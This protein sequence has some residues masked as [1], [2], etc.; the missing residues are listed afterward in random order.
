MTMTSERWQGA[1]S[2]Q[3]ALPR[4]DERMW[5]MGCHL[6][7]FLGFLIPVPG[8]SVVGPLVLWLARRDESAFVEDQGRAA[9]NFQVTIAV[10]YLFSWPL[11]PLLGLGLLT[12][13]LVVLMDAA[14]ILVASIRAS[15]GESYRYPF[16]MHLVGR[17]SFRV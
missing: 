17:D 14:F 8:I 13:G 16:S 6:A 12:M 9:L 1:W 4:S 10:L 5:A 2:R 15:S 11:V 7:G 3:H